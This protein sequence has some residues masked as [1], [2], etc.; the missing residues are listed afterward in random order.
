MKIQNLTL[1]LLAPCAATSITAQA[2]AEESAPAQ[3]FNLMRF[4]VTER[5]TTQKAISGVNLS[6][7]ISWNPTSHLRD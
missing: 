3:R 5:L 6:T 2:Q 4:G 7:L 1:S